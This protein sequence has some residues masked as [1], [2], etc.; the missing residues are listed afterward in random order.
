MSHI[1]VRSSAYITL[2][3]GGKSRRNELSEALTLAPCL[4]AAD[5]GAAVALRYGHMPRTVIGDLDSLDPDT[6]AALPSQVLH[7]IA[8]QD[9]TDF[10][11]ALRS[12]E[13]P[14]VLGV[15]FLGRRVDHQLANF[16][17]LVRRAERRCILIGKRDV[18]LAAPRRIELDLERGSRVSLFPLR[19][20]RGRSDGL[21]WPI[22]GLDFH[23]VGQIGTS[24]RV[25]GRG[26]PVT[27]EFESPG[28][29]LILP[30]KALPAAIDGLMHAR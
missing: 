15:G 7:E 4:V 1:I 12:V 21:H 8:E 3:G 24:N 6:R 13:A 9:S 22:D 30:R 29:L 23:P 28:M 27:L 19:E 2:L 26:G 16:S 18:V 25:S 14:L 17:T 20:M 11:K 5:G 10:D